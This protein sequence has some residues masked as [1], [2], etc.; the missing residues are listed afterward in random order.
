MA[1][2]GGGVAGLAAALALQLEGIPVTVFERDASLEARAQGYGMT[3][4]S[5]NKA[6]VALGVLDELVER[7]TTSTSHW[8]FRCDGRVIGYFGRAFLGGPG[9]EAHGKG[10]S[11]GALRGNLRVPRLVLRQMLLRRLDAG[12]VRWNSKVV[13]VQEDS[14]DGVVID[15]E[16]GRGTRIRQKF[17]CLVAADG[18]RSSLRKFH[19]SVVTHAGCDEGD[20]LNFLGVFVCVGLSRLRHPL[21]R[22]RGFYTYGKRGGRLF[23][24]PYSVD[25]SGEVDKTMWQ[26]SWPCKTEGEALTW[27]KGNSKPGE[28]LDE[29][30]HYVKE[31]HAPV[32]AL[33][34][35]T[36]VSDLWFSPLYDREVL[37]APRKGARSRITV[38]GDSAHPMSMFKGMGANTALHDGP[39]LAKILAKALKT[40]GDKDLVGTAVASWERQMVQRHAKTVHAS[41]RAAQQLHDPELQQGACHRFAGCVSHEDGARLMDALARHGVGAH[42]VAPDD[43]H[44]DA[45]EARV[46]EIGQQTNAFNNTLAASADIKC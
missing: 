5:G 2:A 41:R 28:V 3:I 40:Q 9:G 35:A 1:V 6:L 37:P 36:E 17:A 25:S 16:D 45:F 33:I 26:L 23:V 8:I 24:M 46:R 7:D 18:L 19:P 21:V 31:W 39:H 15:V 10:A 38:V 11:E 12:V 14:K 42:S 32:P 27:A 4:S 43:A 30:R 22:G 13:H 20:P 34:E 29:V 44:L